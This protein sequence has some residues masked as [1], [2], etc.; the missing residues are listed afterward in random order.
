[1]EEERYEQDES[2]EDITATTIAGQVSQ[3]ALQSK[4]AQ[5]I[6]E[7]REKSLV[8]AQ[9]ECEKTLLRLFHLISQDRQVFNE[10]KGI[11]EWQTIED[12]K[13]KILTKQGVE[14]IMN[15]LHSYVNKETLLSNFGESKINQRMMEFCKALNGEMF[16]KYEI[17]FREPSIEECKEIL[18]KRIKTKVKVKLISAEL[19]GKDLDEKEVEKK[20]LDEMEER[21]EYELEKIRFT[22]RKENLKGYEMLF[23]RIKALVEATHH[24]AYRGEERGSLRKMQSVSELISPNR[25]NDNQRNGGFF[26]KW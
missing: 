8:E 21:V 26:S 16:L 20:I 9:L 19:I 10:E 3:Q 22:T 1:M 14:E 24:R 7:E 23:T 13:Q 15:I 17:Y 2:R 18:E 25:N 4:E 12:Q 11:L 5:Y 6:I